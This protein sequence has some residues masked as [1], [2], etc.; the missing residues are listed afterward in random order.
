MQ[1]VDKYPNNCSL[2]YIKQGFFSL[3]KVSV[4]NERNVAFIIWPFK[5]S[6][7]SYEFEFYIINQI[8]FKVV[9]Q[10]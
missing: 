3:S 7:G 9:L 6:D 10:F 1:I 5:A 4:S 2:L 8:F